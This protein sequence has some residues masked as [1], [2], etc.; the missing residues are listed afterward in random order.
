MHVKIQI[1]GGLA[2]QTI[3]I[4]VRDGR[5]KHTVRTFYP[6]TDEKLRHLVHIVQEAGRA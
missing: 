1:E 3:Q 4:T 6:I 2:Y 5:R